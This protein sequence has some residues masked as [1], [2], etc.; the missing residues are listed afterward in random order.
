MFMSRIDVSTL[1]TAPYTFEQLLA[2]AENH[3][4][5]GVSSRVEVKFVSPMHALSVRTATKKCETSNKLHTASFAFKHK[6]SLIVVG[7]QHV[8]RVERD[9]FYFDWYHTVYLNWETGL[10]EKLEQGRFEYRILVSSKQHWKHGVWNAA[11]LKPI[12]LL[13][14]TVLN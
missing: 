11:R 3:E 5:E 14:G 4:I 7:D 9:D 6:S 1:R 12:S 2:F 13:S 8:H 10:I